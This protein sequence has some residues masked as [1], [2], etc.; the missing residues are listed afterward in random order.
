MMASNE[1]AEAA[2]ALQPLLSN[3]ASNDNQVRTQAEESLNAQWVVGQPNTLLAA[4]VQ[5]M[6]TNGDAHSRSFAAILFRRIAFRLSPSNPEGAGLLLYQNLRP[7]VRGF[8]QQGLLAALGQE[9]VVP[10]V[11]K[12]SDTVAEVARFLDNMGKTWPELLQGLATFLRAENPAQRA[13]VFRIFAAVPAVPGAQPLE[14]MKPAFAAGLQDGEPGVR[15]AALQACVAYLGEVEGSVRQQCQE[16]VPAMLAT[17]EPLL[18]SGEESQLVDSFT[19]LVELAENHPK[20]FRPILANVLTFCTQVAANTDLEDSTRQTALELPL[21]LAEAHPAMARKTPNFSEGFVPVALAMMAELD[22]SEEDRAWYTVTDLDHDDDDADAN[23]CLGEQALD[24]LARALGGKYVLPIAFQLIPNYL[25]APQWP[26]RHAGLMAVSAIGEG[27][28]KPMERELGGILQLIVPY[29]KDPHPRVRYAACNC[30]GQLCTDFPATLPTKYHELVLSHLLPA[31]GD[32]ENPRVQAHAA[33][34]LVNFCEEASQAVLEPYLD[35]LLQS[36]LTLLNSPHRFVQ[37]QAVTTIAS[38]ADTAE[39]KFVKYYS[40]IMPMLLNVIRTATQP[41]YRPLRGKTIE[42]ATLIALAVGRD[43]LGPHA[44]ELAQLLSEAQQ[45]VVEADDP[46]V[47]YLIAAWARLCKVMGNDFAPFLPVVMPPLLRS[48]AIKPDFAVLDLDEDASGRYA[49]EDGWEFVTYNGKQIGMRTTALEEKCTAVEM[50]ICY[51]RQLGAGFQP[52]VTPVLEIVLPLLKFHFHEGVKTAA[53]HTL[54]QLLGSLFQHLSLLAPQSPQ[55]Q[56]AEQYLVEVWGMASTKLLNAAADEADPFFAAELF[57]SFADCL[58]VLHRDG[59]HVPC[60]PALQLSAEN[61]DKVVNA[62]LTHTQAYGTRAQERQAERQGQDAGD[63]DEDDEVSE[64]EAGDES[65][66]AEIAKALHQVFA[67][68]GAAFLP[69]FDRLVPVVVAFLQDT[70]SSAAR[71]WAL[72]VFDDLVEFTGPASWVYH[73]HFLSAMLQGLTDEALDVAQASVYGI[74]VAAQYGGPQYAEACAHAAPI[75][76]GLLG[77][78]QARLAEREYVTDNAVASLGKILR[79]NASGVDA[80]ALLS[81]WYA[82]LPIVHDEEECPAVYEYLLELLDQRHPVVMGGTNLDTPTPDA[83]S[84]LV[85]ILAEFLASDVTV[86]EALG[87]RL[88]QTLQA[89]LGA[90]PEPAKLQIRN[91]LSPHQV[92]A[93]ATK[94]WPQ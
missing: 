17:L 77:S 52:Y 3:L 93:L 25:G 5:I 56:A 26:R 20:P 28:A 6:Q 39:Q 72:C 1:Y 57:T 55:R 54:P 21:T 24:R 31:L 12:L 83:A 80:S 78:P 89:C 2:Q 14:A 35:T 90:C 51:A 16:W 49:T 10:V 33:A 34:A 71:Q 65:L 63:E 42:C 40:T 70:F 85:R 60:P 32:A 19:A 50:L 7:D 46:Q 68:H 37:E 38:V 44:A 75:L 91:S 82:G 9:T 30:V 81:A 69:H 92:K 41:E 59:G 23:H 84:R 4:L 61:L 94:G 18:A 86:S 45:N 66:M 43:T 79:Y 27:C 53:A 47:P 74:G 76:A 88:G 8:C 62:V 48:A 64:E 11:H 29:F 67:T 15:L 58:G 73:Q 13:A 22:E 87:Q 36:L